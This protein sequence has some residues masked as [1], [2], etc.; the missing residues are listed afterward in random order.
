M[1]GAV[2]VRVVLCAVHDSFSID[3]S[4]SLILRDDNTAQEFPGWLLILHKCSFL[5]RFFS[6]VG[7]G[8]FI[9]GVT[10]ASF[11]ILIVFSYRVSH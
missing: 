8:L 11:F 2:K 10:F 6:L 9:F 1:I 4:P 3:L 7:L 5:V